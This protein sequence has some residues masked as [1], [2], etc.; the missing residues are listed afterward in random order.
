MNFSENKKQAASRAE[1]LRKILHHHNYRYFILDDPE[2]SDAKYDRLMQELIE[3]ESRFPELS[4]PDSPTRRVGSPPL[5]KFETIMHHVPMRSL[6]KG[7]DESDI[8]A[9]DHRVSRS[10]NTV[11]KIRYTVEPKVDGVAVALV[12]QNGMLVSGATRGDGYTGELITRNVKTIGSIPLV[13]Q[14]H[15]EIDIPEFIDVRGE[16]YMNVSDFRNLNQMR[17][18]QGFP[19]FANPRN[20]SA[21]SL[22]QLDSTITAQRPLK[23][24]V[25][26]VG[27][28]D[29]L[30]VSSH[31]QTI[32]RLQKLGFPVNPHLAATITVEEVVDFF[33]QMDEMRKTLDYEID[34]IV[35]KVD[36]YAYQERL[37]NTSRSP[38]WA[39]A[40][41]FKAM[42]EQTRVQ[43]I[44]VQVGRT[45]A[46]TPVAVLEPVSIGGVTV[47]RAS[48]HN[49]DEVQKKDV[50]KGD[51][52]LVQRAGDVIPEVVKVIPSYRDG[53]QRRFEMPS[54]CPVC[55]RRLIRFRDEAATRCV[56]TGCPAQLKGN[57][58]HFASKSALD[59]DG[60][61]RKLVDQ[62][63]ETGLIRSVADIFRLD[64]ERLE[65][66]DRM[67]RKSAE[68]LVAAIGNSK[69]VPLSRFLYG[70]G[71][72]HV[73][74]HAAKLLAGYFQTLDA[75]LTAQKEDIEK[76]EQVG[77]VMAEAVTAFFALPENRKTIGDMQTLGVDILPE[78]TGGKT[79]SALEGVSF[80]L[81]G[82]LSSMT[83]NEAAQKIEAAGGKVTGSVSGQTG[84]VVAGNS[85]GSKIDQARKKGVAI[86]DE[87]RFIQLLKEAGA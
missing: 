83:R 48:L 19:V 15:E 34:G 5:D 75:L 47:S 81:T 63:V 62:L 1:A 87:N 39:I 43:D 17:L 61:G 8:I 11:E 31:A 29:L 73:G 28:T 56:N 72:R 38:R 44:I 64:V 46:V 65:K 78:Y 77:P 80:V 49:E 82:T 42:Q 79:A 22:R 55:S 37:G 21:G 20:A 74:L 30:G 4:T 71:I 54:H 14:A 13:L 7:F 12:Y 60:L 59:I 45:G 40:V 76:I 51:M 33:R 32:G 2:I 36:R 84:Y 68:N 86:I 3:I 23:M 50:R 85:P 53:S 35:V 9:F 6:D 58:L 16:I 52:V 26:G 69:K 67:G 25:Y 18:A 70:L 27:R 10:L 24:F 57:V 66:L 41:K